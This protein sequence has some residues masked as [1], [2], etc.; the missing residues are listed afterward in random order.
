MK[1][2]HQKRKCRKTTLVNWMPYPENKPTEE[3]EFK[4]FLVTIDCGLG[5]FVTTDQWL[6]VGCWDAYLDRD[7]LAW[8]E[9]PEPYRPAGDNK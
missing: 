5:Q 4:E 7:V 1:V 2:R 9:M 3:D 8:A 6:S